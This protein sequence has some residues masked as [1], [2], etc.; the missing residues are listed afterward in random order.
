M[1]GDGCCADYREVL[2]C[3]RIPEGGVTVIDAI[4]SGTTVTIRPARR[5]ASHL[6]L[7]FTSLALV[8]L[9][10]AVL[11]PNALGKGASTGEL[12]FY[13]CAQ[14][15]PVSVSEDGTPSHPL[16]IGMEKHQIELEAHDILGEGDAACLACHDAP[17]NNPGMLLL[18][19]G[20]LVEVTGDVS[21]VCQRCHFE[22]YTQWQQGVHGKDQPKCTAAGCHDPHTPSWIYIAAL[23]PFQGTGVEVNAVGTDRESFKPFASP[24][25]PP[26]VETPL[27]YVIATALGAVASVGLISSM[28]RGRSKP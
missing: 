24:P 25:V 1:N 6:V 13:P 17:T 2:P 14:C 27:W 26:P 10:Y 22:K 8:V 4:Q 19:D 20:S 3:R 28:V 23:P 16:P 12:A 18:A 21:R 5:R 9:A 7:S 15:H 11:P